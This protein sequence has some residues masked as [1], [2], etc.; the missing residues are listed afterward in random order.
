MTHTAFKFC[1]TT[2]AIISFACQQAAARPALEPDPDKNNTLRGPSVPVET[3][4]SLGSTD[5]N[6][7]FTPVEGRPELAAFALLI[8]DP[9]HL[10]AARDLDNKRL[11]DL[12]FY[13]VDE[14]DAIREITDS[15][16]AGNQAG[17]QVLLAQ[18]RQRFEPDLPRDP[19]SPTLESMLTLDQRTEYNRIINDYWLRWA[20][21]QSDTMNLKQDSEAYKKIENQLNNQLFQQDIQQAYQ[22]SIKR[23]RDSLDAIYTEVQPTDEQR[24][25]IR[26]IMITHIKNTRLEATI[27][28]RQAAMLEIYNLLDDERREKLFLYITRVAISRTG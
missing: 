4:N 22:Y 9:E 26:D 18:L 2:F 17:A 1:C 23:Y 3:Q 21:A 11:S 20:S 8:T 15:M 12:T 5:M 7:Y 19:L 10:A 25:Q 16:T 6:G 13:L 27:E 14:I 28:Q 24:A